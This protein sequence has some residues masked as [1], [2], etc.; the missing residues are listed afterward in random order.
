[1]ERQIVEGYL[2]GL[3]KVERLARERQALGLLSDNFEGIMTGC[4]AGVDIR[5]AIDYI[6][7]LC[8]TKNYFD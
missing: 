5:P 8:K 6:I 4:I 3:V 7:D 1:M 2:M